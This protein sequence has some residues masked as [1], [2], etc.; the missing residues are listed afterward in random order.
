MATI[1][2][3][4]SKKQVFLL[5]LGDL[6]ALIAALFIATV[7][8]Y[9][10]LPSE[11]LFVSHLI[12]FSF[13]FIIA[14]GIYFIAGLYEK[15]TFVL[16]Q[17]IPRI[18]IQVQIINAIIAVA[19]FY[20]VPYFSITPKLFLFIYLLLALI[21]TTW[22]RMAMLYLFETKR[23]VSAVLLTTRTATEI[24]ELRSE[25]EHN[26]RYGIHFE[27]SISPETRLVVA[28]FGDKNTHSQIP[29]LYKLIFSGVEFIDLRQLYEDLFDRVPLSLVDDAWCLENISSTSKT[30]FDF[31]KRCMDMIVSLIIGVI[32]LVFYPFVYIAIKIDDGGVIFSTQ[33]RVGQN[34]SRVKIFKFRTM[35]VANDGGK[36]GS[37]VNV[38]TRIGKFLR[39]SRIDELPQLWNVFR[40]DVSLIGPRPEFPD[41]V[42]S[43]SSAIPYY[44]LRHI[45]KPG[46]SGWAQIYHEKHPHHGIDTEETKN[47]ASYDLY[48]VK[49]RS[50]FLD[51]K[52]A[53][54]TL[55]VLISFMGK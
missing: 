45:V 19:F 7:V 2:K 25:V 22:W 28:D 9:G 37:Q 3:I 43:Y 53:L 54:R 44:N 47:K 26:P 16:K 10:E 52:I 32:S 20:F 24:D 51:I 46:L 6:L 27:N 18:L 15:H 38:V 35:S 11:V 39:K 48:Y 17:R 13:L 8:R 4:T 42:A 31:A 23:S 5:F 33:E 34:G 55:K 30:V 29:A 49:N 14:I 12:P 50:F 40:G 21:L 36:W 41:P 1:N